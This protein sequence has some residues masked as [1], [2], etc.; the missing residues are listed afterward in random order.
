MS[1]SWFDLKLLISF[2]K[3][4][5]LHCFNPQDENNYKIDGA[6]VITEATHAYIL[7]HIRSTKKNV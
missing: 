5:Y 2:F 3:L 6:H 7:P 1:I 4:H